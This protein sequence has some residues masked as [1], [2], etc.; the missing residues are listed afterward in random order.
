NHLA[1]AA[2]A[3]QRSRRRLQLM[4]FEAEADAYTV[5]FPFFSKVDLP[6]GA[7]SFEPDIPADPVTLLATTVAL[8]VDKNWA[9]Q[10]PSLIKVL[11]DAVI[12]N[13]RIGIDEK[14]QKPFLFQR[15]GQFPS[16]DDPEFKVSEVAQSVYK[17]GE[18]PFLL[19][20]TAKMSE[21]VPF[22]VAAYLDTHGT[23]QGLSLIAFITILVPLTPSIP[24]LYNWTVRR[25]ILYWYRRLQALEQKLAYETRVAAPAYASMPEIDRIDAAVRRIRVPLNFTDQYYELR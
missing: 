14:T 2:E 16:L 6:R 25:R 1:D 7:I 10:N 11:T 24:A 15:N 3:E 22:A 21:R 9:E 4:N 5:R 20:R 17:S 13:P 19:S 23:I 18:L 12:H 8:L